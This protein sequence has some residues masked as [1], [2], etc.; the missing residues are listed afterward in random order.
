VSTPAPDA[1]R[2]AAAPS[3]ARR[4]A[5]GVLERVGHGGAYA[6][7]AL[8][9]AL[10][11]EPLA[12]RDRALATELVYG[13]LRWRGRLDFALAHVLARPLDT[14]EPRVADLLR[15]GAYQLLFCDR[16]PAAAAVSESVLLARAAGLG[17]AAGLVNAVLRRLARERDAIPPPALEVDP[18]G[19]LVHGLSIPAWVAERWLAARAPEEAAALARACNTPAPRTVRVHRLRT[20]REALLPSL[21]ERHSD[22]EPCRY[23]PDGIRVGGHGDLARDPAFRAGLMTVQDEASQLVVELLDPRPGERVLDACAAPGA[24]ATAIAERVGTGG[25]VVGLDRHPRR[26]ALLARDAERLG[27]ANVRTHCADASADLPE[28]VAAG[29]FDRVLVDAPCSGLGTWRR[30]P[31][32]RWR[33]APDAPARLAR[34]QLAILRRVWPLVA[35]GGVLVY[36]TCTFA[37]EENEAVIDALLAETTELVRA[38]AS[39]LSESDLSE[40][41]L[42]E[43]NSRVSPDLAPLLDPSGALRTLP[44]RHDTDGFF[45]VRL[46]RR[47]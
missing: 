25:L 38:P 46:E 30:N 23:A 31:D 16:V 22:V 26:L 27:L 3:A 45:A 11:R 4:V 42:S 21:R 39:N 6:D 15:L 8:H 36:S 40:S 18:V 9:A 14:L 35:P 43:S 7:L 33:L 41:N 5:A 34:V 1:A 19:H 37:P 13:T 47:A 44:H 29:G 24:K 28:V 12:T 17:R 20:S 10:E 2:A 32:A